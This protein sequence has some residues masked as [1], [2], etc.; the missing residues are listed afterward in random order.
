[1]ARGRNVA[2]TVYLE[3]ECWLLSITVYSSSGGFT[4]NV[5]IW[6]GIFAGRNQVAGSLWAYA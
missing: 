6:P 1:M 4:A 3:P 2:L 5:Q